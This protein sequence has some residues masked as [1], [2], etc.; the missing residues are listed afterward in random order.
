MTWLRKYTWENAFYL[1]SA[2]I[3]CNESWRLTLP[4]LDLSRAV[5][6]FPLNFFPITSLSF[7]GMAYWCCVAAMGCLAFSWRRFPPLGMAVWMT[8]IALLFSFGK[9]AYS[10][11]GFVFISM[12]LSWSYMLNP[13]DE[14]SRFDYAATGATFFYTASGLWKLRDLAM[15]GATW[16]AAKD[17]LPVDIAFGLA[18]RYRDDGRLYLEFFVA[19]STLSALTWFAVIATEIFVPILVVFL[20][21]WR[22]VLFTVF[23][24]FHAMAQWIVGPVFHPQMYLLGFLA[25]VSFYQV[26]VRPLLRGVNSAHG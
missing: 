12:A 20:P 23:I 22:F 1:L 7:Y 15:Q 21:R 2:I 16:S 26:F 3:F 13:R 8:V 9:I 5:W 25:A 17:Y 11:H 14:S 19:H 24:I 10:L 6:L 4:G 18:E